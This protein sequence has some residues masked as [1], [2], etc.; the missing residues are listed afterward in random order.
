MG[1][2]CGNQINIFRL[3]YIT[4]S[5][6]LSACHLPLGGRQLKAPLREGVNMPVACWLTAKDCRGGV[7]AMGL[8]MS[9]TCTKAETSLWLEEKLNI[10]RKN[11][12]RA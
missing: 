12:H 9:E 7:R 10:I 11:P 3:R 2:I 1:V 5:V 4:P 8:A 6:T